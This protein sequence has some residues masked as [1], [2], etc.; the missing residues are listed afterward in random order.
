V[1]VTAK[2]TTGAT[3]STSFTWSVTTAGGG[4][5]VT[6]TNPGSQVWI[7]GY[8]FGG[9]QTK[10]SDSKNLALKFSATGLPSGMAISSYGDITG[11]PTAAGTFTVKVTATD[12]GGA[13]GGTAFTFTVYG[14]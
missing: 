10:A 4:G 8:P 3:G 14:F 6:V 9:L 5:T 12:T 13:T 11:T 7:T 2:D 1:T